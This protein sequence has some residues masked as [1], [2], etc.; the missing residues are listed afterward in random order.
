MQ[1][2]RCYSTFLLDQEKVL[3]I[4]TVGKILFAFLIWGTCLQ[5]LAGLLP[6]VL[7]YSVPSSI[8]I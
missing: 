1:A 4:Y 6:G 7:M 5:K 8:G 2:P 3:Q